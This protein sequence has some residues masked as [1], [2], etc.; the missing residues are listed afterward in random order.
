MA[1]I[2]YLTT[3]HPYV[4]LPLN[5]LLWALTAVLW[6]RILLPLFPDIKEW[7]W[8]PALLVVVLPSSFTWTT[9]FHKDIFVIPGTFVILLGL[10][11]SM[12]NRTCSLLRN[13]AMLLLTTALG[14]ALIWIARPYYL[15]L[16]AAGTLATLFIAFPGWLL[17]RIPGRG[18]ALVVTSTL[19]IMLSSTI[20]NQ[21]A[22]NQGAHLDLT[23]RAIEASPAFQGHSHQ[24]SSPSILERTVVRVSAIRQGYCGNQSKMGTPVDCDFQ[25]ETIE[26]ALRY[27]P[28]AIQIALLSP[29]PQTWIAPG[30]TP[31][32]SQMRW[33]A[34]AET[35]LAYFILLAAAATLVLLR[36]S[37]PSIETWMVLLWLTI[38]AIIQTFANPNLG[39][40]YRMRYP[41]WT[42]IL[43]I[44]LS[45]VLS[46]WLT[47]RNSEVTN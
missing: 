38:P 7:V 12:T 39:T 4:L 3:P 36:S 33:I 5:A 16:L 17:G 13:I 21:N 32:G 46:A 35:L 41:F 1:A 30:K 42:G 28:R 10:I 25:L 14:S 31:G 26:D 37:T 11:T 40:L 9:Q 8:L 19:M 29:F 45:I 44:C 22:G 47:R 6:Q 18:V 24:D 20:A 2:Y 15:Q 27:L 34:G 43:S 23:S